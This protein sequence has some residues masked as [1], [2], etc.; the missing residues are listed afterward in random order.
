MGNIIKASLIALA[1]MLSGCGVDEKEEVVVEQKELKISTEYIAESTYWCI[2]QY[3][4]V[5]K[6]VPK[7][8]AVGTYTHKHIP[9]AFKAN[10]SIFHVFTNLKD[11][12][13]YV[14]AMKDNTEKVLIHTIENWDD[15]HTNAVIHVLESG[16]VHVHV[17]SRGIAHKFQSGAILVSQTP[18]ELDFEC[19]DG[20]EN[21]NFESYPQIWETTWGEHVGYTHYMYEENDPMAYR[22]LWSRIGDV[23]QKLVHGGHYSIRYYDGEYSYMAYNQ[24]VNGHPDTRINLYMM[25][26]KDGVN[27]TTLDDRPLTVPLETHNEDAMIYQSMGNVYLKDITVDDSVKIL[28]TE[29]TSSDPTQGQR[30]VKEWK[31]GQIRTITETNHNYNAGAYIGENILV[32]QDGIEGW[33]G[34][35]IVLYENYVE[36]QRDNTSNCNYIRKVVNSEDKAVVSCDNYHL[37]EAAS[38]YI[39]SLDE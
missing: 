32:T 9:L 31:D 13:F 6:D 17:A 22:T 24:L 33:T 18:Y 25:K 3:Y 21:E 2:P 39:L 27:W 20:C 34:G 23:R 29:S 8:C 4:G 11:G 12:N 16:I 35:D 7:Y 10:D 26:T 38:H 15:P 37:E 1:V 19:V 30:F 5:N 36:T 14:Y 28:F